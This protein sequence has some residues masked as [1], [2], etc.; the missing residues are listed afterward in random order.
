MRLSPGVYRLTF[1]LPRIIAEAAIAGDHRPSF[2]GCK[3]SI[4]RAGIVEIK[5]PSKEL[6]FSQGR[7]LVRVLS[8]GFEAYCLPARLETPLRDRFGRPYP[9][10]DT[11]TIIV[12]AEVAF[13]PTSLPADVNETT[14]FG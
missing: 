7:R 12:N 5:G 8:K 14:R 4:S 2:E 11:W 3:L 13:S 9:G 6:V 1:M 10:R